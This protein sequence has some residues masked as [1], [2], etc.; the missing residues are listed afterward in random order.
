[1]IE[2]SADH[3]LVLRVA[4]HHLP[5]VKELATVKPAIIEKLKREQAI[6]TVQKKID[7]LKA[8]AQTENSLANVAG[9]EK[10]KIIT[11]TNKTRSDTAEEGEM[12]PVVFNLS[13]PAKDQ[14]TIDSKEM[15]NG[16]YVLVRLFAVED[17]QMT[18]DR[19]EFKAAEKQLK[20]GVGNLQFATFEKQ[21][22]SKAKIINHDTVVDSRPPSP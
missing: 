16:D 15:A 13:K 22:R 21:L 5:V 10:L 19:P 2:L 11:V 4:E 3:A 18:S 8:K 9:A 1:M 6:A 12:I 7:N 14:G 20:D 17:T